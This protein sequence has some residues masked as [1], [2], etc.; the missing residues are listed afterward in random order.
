MKTACDYTSQKI[1]R[2]EVL[3][4]AEDKIGCYGQPIVQWE[5]RCECGDIV[6]RRTHHLKRGNCSCKKCKAIEE[7]KKWGFEEIRQHHWA[8]I[9]RQAAK[10]EIEFGISVQYA[11]DLFLKQNRR[12]ALSG[13]PISFSS[14]KQ[15]HATGETTASLDRI[16]SSKGYI[17]SNIQWL[18]K[19][20]NLMKSDFTQDEFL[21]YCRVI[22]EYNKGR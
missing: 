20:V 7:A 8:T 12:C 5:C 16:D 4:R 6:Y 21:N 9:Q 10:R 13:L 1:G 3:R 19:W 22:I 11:W 17:E 18:H 2:L 15:G 14:T